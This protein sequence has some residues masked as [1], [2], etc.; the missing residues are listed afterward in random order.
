MLPGLIFLNRKMLVLSY[1]LESYYQLLN[2]E[3]MDLE[4]LYEEFIDFK[5]IQL[6]NNEFLTRL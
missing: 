2:F 3:E 6:A 4:K 1:F 5:T